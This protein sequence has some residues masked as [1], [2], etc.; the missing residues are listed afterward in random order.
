MSLRISRDQAPCMEL[1]DA[2]G[3]EIGRRVAIVSD[4]SQFFQGKIIDFAMQKIPHIDDVRF[5]ELIDNGGTPA[6]P[7][8]DEFLGEVVIKDVGNRPNFCATI[9]QAIG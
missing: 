8:D 9:I 2:S 4:D 7:S 6:D 5:E 1:D 3:G